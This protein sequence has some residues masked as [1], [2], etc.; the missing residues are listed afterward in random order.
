MSDHVILFEHIDFR[1]A[2]KHVFRAEGNLNAADDSFFND[3]VSS[4]AVLS[5]NWKF[6]KNANFGG[7]YPPVLGPGLYPWVGNVG[8]QN[9]DMSSLEL[10]PLAT[11]FTGTAAFVIANSNFPGPFVQALNLS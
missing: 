1:G 2:H 7:P 8:V 5:G 3:K 6:C 11:A 9:D 4:I 10:E